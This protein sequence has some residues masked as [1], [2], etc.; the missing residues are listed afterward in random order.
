MEDPTTLL[1]DKKG[2][3][4]SETEA[5]QPICNF[6]YYSEHELSLRFLCSGFCVIRFSEL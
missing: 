3:M 1:R 5:T 6:D 4:T 2:E